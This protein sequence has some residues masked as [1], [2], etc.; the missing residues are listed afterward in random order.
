[1][2][3]TFCFSRMR[4]PNSVVLERRWPD[5]FA[6]LRNKFY[7]DELYEAS[8]VWFNARWAWVCDWL[9]TWIWNGAVQLVSYLLLGLSWLNRFFDEY[10][11]NL[12]FDQG[13]GRISR[14]GK[15]MSSFQN[16]RVQN[17][18]RVIGVALTVLVLILIWGCR[19]S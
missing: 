18:L 15:L 10:V 3:R 1:M 9:D 4:T 14:G 13:C 6:L 8:V 2:R 12:G 17:Y 7:V 16:G 11:I 19:T 5:V